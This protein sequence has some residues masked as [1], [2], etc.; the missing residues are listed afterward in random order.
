MPLTPAEFRLLA[1]LAETPG[2]VFSHESLIG[3]LHNDHRIVSDRTI[4]SHVT[5][6]RRKIADAGG[7]ENLVRSIYGVG[8]KM[9]RWE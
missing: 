6:L 8:Y 2:R 7:D 5:N 3:V 4:D 9:E 1:A